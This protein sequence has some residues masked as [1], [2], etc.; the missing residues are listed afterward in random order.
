MDKE[1]A[2]PAAK[3]DSLWNLKSI[4]SK[5]TSAAAAENPPNDNPPLPFL[6]A[7]TNSVVSRCSKILGISAKELQALFDV[8]LPDNLRQPPSYARNF[9]EF[10]SYKA[11]HLATTKPNYLT[12]KEFCHLTFDMMVAWDDP[13]VDSNLIDKETASCSN[14]DVEGEDGWSL[15]YFNSTKMAFQVDDKKTVGPEAFARIAPACPIIA[16]VTTVHNLFDVLTSSSGSRLHFLKYDKYLRSLDKVA[17]SA[18]NALGPQAIAALSLADDEIIIDVDGTVP[19]Q[20]V[21]QHIG[22]SAWPGR[23]TLTNHALYFEPGVGLYDKAVKYDLA[24]DMKQVVKPELTGPLGARLFDKAVMYKSTT[25]AEPVYLEFPEFKGCSRRDYW[26]DICLEILRAH[27]FNRKYSLK[28]NQQSEV[29]A[30]AILGIFQFH[31]VR[32]AFRIALS[33]Y[34]ALLC[35]NLAESLP[36]GDMIIETLAS[37]IALITPSAGQQEVS[38]SPN[39]NRQPIFPVAFLTL[40]RLRIVSPKEGE[41]NVEA[42]YPAG[43]LHVGVANPLEAVV[44]QLE[45]NTGKAEAAQATVDQVKVEGIDTNVAVMKELLFPVIEIYSRIE[46]LASWNDP[47]K[48]LMFV[49]IFSYLIVR[50]WSKYLV[51]SILVFIALVMLWRKYFWRRRQLEAC[52][53]VAPPSKNAVEQLLLLQEAISQIESLIQSGN[54]ALLKIRALLF[55]V[56]PQATDKLSVVLFAM[57]LGLVFVP[58]RYVILMGFLE[59]FTRYMPLRRE[60]TE[61]GMRRLKEW[62][63]RIPAAPVQIVKPDDKKRK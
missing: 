28:G 4:F 40:I 18:Q 7:H 9:L 3:N 36:G 59:Y 13:G 32:E 37:Q 39:A 30:R 44:K 1:N 17:K 15:F 5:K 26:L 11:L 10:C 61:R 24:T 50:G 6:A 19:T 33:N 58:V 48:S 46:R 31:A 2:E 14:Q 38:V 60:D 43:N 62:W 47:Y 56:A 53:I 25:T 27:R 12:D 51:P 41:V 34:K 20:P 16:D 35:F 23:L 52:K 8:E 42:T 29:L 54:V 45:Q 55:A 49:V 63:I 21:L 57:A 22:M